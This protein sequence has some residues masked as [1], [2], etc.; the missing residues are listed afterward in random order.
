MAPRLAARAAA[1]GGGGGWDKEPSPSHSDANVDTGAATVGCA[2]PYVGKRAASS[3]SPAARAI[4]FSGLVAVAWCVRSAAGTSDLAPAPI[5]APAT[6]LP[7]AALVPATAL[8]RTASVGSA[9]SVNADSDSGGPRSSNMTARG[10]GL[11]KRRDAQ[12]DNQTTLTRLQTL[13]MKS[14]RRRSMG[15]EEAM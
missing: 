1:G 2:V 15:G 4:P 3:R 8:G 7:R 14:P 11:N 12:V 6:A 10:D 9:E 13:S 5:P